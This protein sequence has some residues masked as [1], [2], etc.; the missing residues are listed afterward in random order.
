MKIKTTKLLAI[1]LITAT[2]IFAACSKDDTETIQSKKENIEAKIVGKWKTATINGVPAYTNNKT[3]TTYNNDNTAT[4]SL[5]NSLGNSGWSNRL[6]FTW[7]I[8]GK[9]VCNKFVDTGI[10]QYK[11][12]IT[13][14]DKEFSYTYTKTVDAQGVENILNLSVVAQKVLVDYSQDIVGLWECTEMTGTVTYGDANHRISYRADGTY[15][16]FSLVEEQ[17][18]HENTLNE[19]IVDGDW[20]A[21]RWQNNGE[22]VVNYECWDID[23]IKDG[24]MKWSALREDTTTN[25]P[26]YTTFTWKKIETT[27]TNA[28]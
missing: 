1:A 5:I 22:E 3:V 28:F 9:T 18:V 8:D 10:S 4:L 13:I 26:F 19:W 25:E 16:Y 7:S 21:M 20:I 23:Y 12:A 24:V 15:T 2:T 11:D 27:S 6:P 17:W 14:D